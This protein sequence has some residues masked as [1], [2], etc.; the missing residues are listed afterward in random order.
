MIPFI[1]A[2]TLA[3]PQLQCD[4]N[5]APCLRRLVWE[6]YQRAETAESKSALLDKALSKESQARQEAEKKAEKSGMFY[7]HPVFWL[8]VGLV[9]GIVMGV[10]LEKR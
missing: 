7:T 5:D 3:A 1:L 10:E 8:G 9:A 2:L 4:I 6:Q